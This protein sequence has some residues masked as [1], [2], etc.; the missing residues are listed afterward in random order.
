MTPDLVPVF[1]R[2]NVIIDLFVSQ[3]PSNRRI[4]STVVQAING[5]A[6]FEVFWGRNHFSDDIVANVRKLN[7][8]YS[9]Y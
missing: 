5:T 4:H 6:E 8:F 2:T 9:L 7:V 3:Y 1:N